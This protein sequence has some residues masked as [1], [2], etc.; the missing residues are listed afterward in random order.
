MSRYSTADSGLEESQR[1]GGRGRGRRVSNAGKWLGPLLKVSD[2]PE[3][4]W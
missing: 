1:Q 4:P 2:Q 3:C